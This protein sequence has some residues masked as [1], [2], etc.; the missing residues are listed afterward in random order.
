VRL[1]FL[2]LISSLIDCRSKHESLISELDELISR[3]KYEKALTLIQER[4]SANRS[5]AEVIS[6]SKPNQPRLLQLS[7][8]R[9]KV[10]WTENK[11]IFYKDLISDKTANLELKIRPESLQI[12][13]NAEYAILQYPLKQKGG[14]A[15]YA[16]SLL[17]ITVEYESAVHIPC[18]TG[19]GISEKGDKIFYFF[20]ND[21]YEEK[22]SHP[23]LPKK[24][25][26]TEQFAPPFPKLKT[27]LQLASIGEDWL[28]WS[29]AGGSYNLY[30][31]QTKTLK[32][33]LLSKDIVIPRVIH[34]NGSQAYVVGGKIGDLYL[35]EIEYSSNRF[36]SISRGIPISTREAISYRL[37]AKD[38][39]IAS[40]QNDPQQ[41]MKWKVLGKKEHLP[42]FLERLWGIAGD[43]MIY[44]SKS[45]ELIIDHLIFSEEDFAM[46]EYFK[47]VKKLADG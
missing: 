29:G 35:R 14:C 33:N 23:K 40:N 2:I 25:I 46:Y 44:E 43:R 7:E 19:M 47:K 28:I 16:Y 11:T 39:F 5:S 38:E 9:T 26:T 4:L 13:K 3:E 6:K 42:F 31:L 32:V 30:V 41:P 34:H 27:N 20:E 15:I 12:A 18:N 45:G 21:L 10:V 8:D 1:F 17:N 22:T 24:I 36:P 37:T